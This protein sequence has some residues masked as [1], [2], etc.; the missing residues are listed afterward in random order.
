MTI[1]KEEFTKIYN[2]HIEQIYRFCYLKTSSRP[3]AEDLAQGAFLRFLEHL[4][5]QEEEIENVRAFLYQ[6]A[7][8]MVIDHYREKGKAPVSLE[9]DERDI[10]IPNG[11]PERSPPRKPIAAP[12][13]GDSELFGQT[14]SAPM[15]AP[16]RPITNPKGT[17]VMMKTLRNR[18][19]FV[20]GL[21]PNESASVCRAAALSDVP[22][23]H[24]IVAPAARNPRP[25]ER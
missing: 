7:R 16:K 9:E 10:A 14:V 22:P 11:T 17:E 2:D 25:C 19:A 20:T 12:T 13:V 15:A 24:F 8:N 5:K 6:I 3:D 4:K 1:S 18:P 23:V 21:R